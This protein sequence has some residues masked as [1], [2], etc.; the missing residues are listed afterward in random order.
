LYSVKILILVSNFGIW[1]LTGGLAAMLCWNN[2]YIAVLYWLLFGAL[3]LQNT[4]RTPRRIRWYNATVILSPSFSPFFTK[5]KYLLSV[6]S[7]S[8]YILF[9]FIYTFKS[10]VVTDC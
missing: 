6:S 10:L 9:Y 3:R 1:I 5:G 7:Y 2:M 4:Y 8:P